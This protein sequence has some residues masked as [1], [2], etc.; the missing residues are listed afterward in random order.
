MVP[1]SPDFT[2]VEFLKMSEFRSLNDELPESLN[3]NYGAQTKKWHF[4]YR[5]RAW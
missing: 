2:L 1:D 5:P 3:A 4:N